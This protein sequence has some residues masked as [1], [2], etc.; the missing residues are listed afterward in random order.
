MVLIIV[1]SIVLGLL[2][3]LWKARPPRGEYVAMSSIP[4]ELCSLDYDRDIVPGARIENGVYHHSETPK[5]GASVVGPIYRGMVHTA[6]NSDS[7]SLT[8]AIHQRLL[9]NP[10]PAC[11]SPRMMAM[12]LYG[13]RK[14]L[15]TVGRMDLP[16]FYR[17]VDNPR[18][19]PQK[20]K[21]Y[22]DAIAA[23]PLPVKI[24]CVR[25]A[26]VKQETT[27]VRVFRNFG[28]V[29]A[30][31]VNAFGAI[32]YKVK[33]RVILAVRSRILTLYGARL[34]HC[35]R[36]NAK[37]SHSDNPYLLKDTCGSNTVTLGAILVN[38]AHGRPTPECRAPLIEEGAFDD[39]SALPPWK[40]EHIVE[41]DGILTTSAHLLV[42]DGSA[43]D[44]TVTAA[45]MVGGA[46]AQYMEIIDHRK[47]S[48]LE[49]LG[50]AS[51]CS[52][53]RKDALSSL[54]DRAPGFG[55][56]WLAIAPRLRR[57]GAFVQKSARRL[58]SA[59]IRGF[60]SSS[61][62]S[63]DSNTDN[64]NGAIMA[65][66][67]A[68]SFSLPAL[69][70]D[71]RPAIA[72]K[73]DD[74]SVR[75]PAHDD[76][77][78]YINRLSQTGMSVT[79]YSTHVISQFDHCSSFC[80]PALRDGVA[81]WA[82]TVKPGRIVRSGVSVKNLADLVSD[83]PMVDD[84]C[85]IVDTT[86]WRRK[87]R[88]AKPID[89]LT[90]VA[91]AFIV[92]YGHNP[93]VASYYGTI[94][95]QC[96]SLHGNAYPVRVRWMSGPALD[97]HPDSYIA[98]ALRYDLDP[99]DI[100][101]LCSRLESLEYVR[102]TACKP[103]FLVWD[104][105][106]F[107]K[108]VAIDNG[109][110]EMPGAAEIQPEP[111]AGPS[112]DR[113]NAD[114]E[115]WSLADREWGSIR[116]GYKSRA[117]LKAAHLPTKGEV[118]ILG[119]KGGG[120][121]EHLHVPSS[122][123]FDYTDFDCRVPWDSPTVPGLVPRCDTLLSDLSSSESVRDEALHSELLRG[124][125]NIALAILRE[126]G[127]FI[128][129]LMGF[130]HMFTK[131]VILLATSYFSS[132][133]IV[134]VP[135]MKPQSNEWF[136]CFTG[137]QPRRPLT[138][139]RPIPFSPSWFSDTSLSIDATYVLCRRL[140]TCQNFGRVPWAK[141]LNRA[142]CRA[143]G[144][145]RG[146]VLDWGGGKGQL[147]PCFEGPVDVIEPDSSAWAEY[148]RTYG[149]DR[150]RRVSS[151]EGVYD[152]VVFSLSADQINLDTDVRKLIASLPDRTIVHVIRYTGKC[153]GENPRWRFVQF[154]GDGFRREFFEKP[155]RLTGGVD[156]KSKNPDVR[157]YRYHR[158]RPC[159]ARKA[160]ALMTILGVV[161]SG[162]ATTGSPADSSAYNTITNNMSRPNRRVRPDQYIPRQTFAAAAYGDDSPILPVHST[163]AVRHSSYYTELDY[164]VEGDVALIAS[165]VA[166]L[167]YLF[168]ISGTPNL[169][170]VSSTDSVLSLTNGVKSFMPLG[171]KM[172]IINEEST[173][174][175]SGKVMVGLASELPPIESLDEGLL[176]RALD[177]EWGR[178]SIGRNEMTSYLP[179]T[180]G[181]H[182][183]DE[184]VERMTSSPG[185]ADYSFT[186]RYVIDDA[187]V[188]SKYTSTSAWADD[189][190]ILWQTWEGT[191]ATPVGAVSETP[192]IM[193]DCQLELHWASEWSIPSGSVGQPLQTV[194]DVFTYAAGITRETTIPVASD[195][196]F[197]LP[198]AHG[199][200]GGSATIDL[201]SAIAA[202]NNAL[203]SHAPIVG[204]RLRYVCFN[205]L[206]YY[207]S[208]LPAKDVV[209]VRIASRAHNAF[210]RDAWVALISPG[211]N[212][213]QYTF[214]MRRAMAY[215]PTE[216]QSRLLGEPRDTLTMAAS[217]DLYDRVRA[218]I[219]YRSKPLLE[220]RLV[221]NTTNA[222]SLSDLARRG[223]SELKGLARSGADRLVD[224]GAK[225][226]KSLLHSVFAADAKTTYAMDQKTS[227]PDLP[228][229]R[230]DV[231]H[232]WETPIPE[233]PYVVVHTAA[234]AAA[235]PA[236]TPPGE[237]PTTSAYWNGAG[238]SNTCYSK[239]GKYH[240]YLGTSAAIQESLAVGVSSDHAPDP[241]HLSF[242]S[243]DIPE[244]SPVTLAGVRVG[245]VGRIVNEGYYAPTAGM[246]QAVATVNR[247]YK[248]RKDLFNRPTLGSTL[249]ITSTKMVEGSSI[250]GA[251]FTLLTEGDGTIVVSA[252]AG[253]RERGHLD[254]AGFP[255]PSL[256]IGGFP[257][258]ALITEHPSISRMA[259]A[260]TEKQPGVTHFTTYAKLWQITHGGRQPPS[261]P[262]LPASHPSSSSS[263]PKPA[264]TAAGAPR[265][266]RRR[267]KPVPTHRT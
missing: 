204:I 112:E 63:G 101:A 122:H 254:S 37:Q 126:D 103:E 152:H 251:L 224:Q 207:N 178:P 194:V 183:M 229:D 162:L 200:S 115:T 193:G 259:A 132:V 2:F 64:G 240:L 233:P 70:G 119:G 191:N 213:N 256:E 253:F 121:A 214:S 21:E 144:R 11:R 22:I 184:E 29:A 237:Y 231:A 148:E 133:S 174:N 192:W 68:L 71:D 217:N 189:G 56:F 159:V 160:L 230:A 42:V 98:L 38:T 258:K 176:T 55:E 5:Q 179:Q 156:L 46:S 140:Y 234:A 109:L 16:S 62:C 220:G 171:A 85:L 97:V 124:A 27:L 242:I 134:K 128:C 248:A 89:H 212:A 206:A 203:D 197:N 143:L 67:C 54:I 94:L 116:C 65:T 138:T 17:V 177:A 161:I 84:E 261:R 81:I 105:P 168:E 263:K 260:T 236:S 86:L 12:M 181:H 158:I 14:F 137:F 216:A 146:R 154:S 199:A 52:G 9:K 33:P 60:K 218:A 147:F 75:L 19:A 170:G 227:A 74:A 99:G 77:Q 34:A 182:W 175:V 202:A 104:D 135:G 13:M 130:D 87:A 139:R 265:P 262:S 114:P 211:T 117:W 92:A 127:V 93:I 198:G 129:K 96:E 228:D 186:E 155:L 201:R 95:R 107:D 26:F 8:S 172:S 125:L 18:W 145:V 165:P 267:G 246:F 222:F 76:P 79:A 53:I 238:Y 25:E 57:C 58:G 110:C 166:A 82:A 32:Y 51:Y 1:C 167:M 215:I 30:N 250:T 223:F 163:R 205:P 102:G 49:L 226:A 219:L 4:S 3:F 80:I 173:D 235:K 78:A 6:V 239:D 120:M 69:L 245:L 61:R 123:S 169:V 255:L 196:V 106:I 48:I 20:R 195:E 28:H 23:E 232:P 90:S 59:V 266:R 244:A 47:P 40:Y 100:R 151:P 142:K 264:T 153:R 247:L 157:R 41:Y 210:Q 257:K 208:G 150:L 164:N 43:F 45:D 136:A 190:A 72:V 141:E 88:R 188:R 209:W 83:E 44:S 185:D 10:P 249:A 243:E 118:V 31:A 91:K 111:P 108:I 7:A 149:C 180:H 35:D 24:D 66:R 221:P 36:R 187:G 39:P 241:I 113:D 252:V 15:N 73:S 225:S 131:A 50:L